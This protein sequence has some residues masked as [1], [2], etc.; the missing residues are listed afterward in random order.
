MQDVAPPSTRMSKESESNMAQGQ[1]L[2]NAAWW[3]RAIPA[4]MADIASKQRGVG[5]RWRERQ[6]WKKAFA[7]DKMPDEA[8]GIGETLMDLRLH[9]RVTGLCKERATGCRRA[10]HF[11][12]QNLKK[13]WLQIKSKFYRM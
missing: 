11:V 6:D 5:N 12:E 13:Y 4:V 7:G 8:S 10:T 1:S 3:A 2:V 9:G